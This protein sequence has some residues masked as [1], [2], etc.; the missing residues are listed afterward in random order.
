M[1]DITQSVVLDATLNQAGANP[2]NQKDWAGFDAPP[3]LK[4]SDFGQG[5]YAPAVSDEVEVVITDEA[6]KA[7]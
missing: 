6:E 5:A 3:T 1:N 7:G 2:I 4:R